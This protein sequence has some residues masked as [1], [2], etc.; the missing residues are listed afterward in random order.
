MNKTLHDRYYNELSDF[1]LLITDK[2]K[3]FKLGSKIEKCFWNY[4]DYIAE[5]IQSNKIRNMYSFIQ[6]YDRSIKSIIIRRFVAEFTKINKEMPISGM[7]L[8]NKSRN[9]IMLVRNY[10]SKSWSFPKGKIEIYSDESSLECA[11]RECLEE[12]NYDAKN[13]KIIGFVSRYICGR[14]TYFYVIDCV[15]EDYEFS[16]SNPYEIEKLKWH[17]FDTK[18]KHTGYNIY[19]NLLFDEIS[20]IVSSSHELLPNQK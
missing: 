11:Y 14:M 7:I 5:S 17:D 20:K 18:L 13:H 19:I 15:P 16:C 6:E 2:K 12:T 1:C 4:N 8:L 3:I 9:K 10:K